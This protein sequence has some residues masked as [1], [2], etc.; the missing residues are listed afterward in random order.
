LISQ[1]QHFLLS[2]LCALNE[3]LIFVWL[4]LICL[5]IFLFPPLWVDL[6][7]YDPFESNTKF[8]SD[9]FRKEERVESLS[10]FIRS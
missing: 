5:C 1:R 8:E 6:F 3:K 7:V 4:S 2:S 10:E 9:V